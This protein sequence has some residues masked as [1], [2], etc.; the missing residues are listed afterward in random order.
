MC[1]VQK[2]AGF[3]KEDAKTGN[4]TVW[5]AERQGNTPSKE[6]WLRRYRMRREVSLN[7]PLRR[8]FSETIHETLTDKLQISDTEAVE[9]Y[10]ASMLIEFLNFDGIYAIRDAT[11]RRVESVLEMLAEG[12]VRMN[13]DSFDREREVHRHIGDFLLFWSGL[14][15]EYLAGRDSVV[16][17][18]RQGQFSYHVVSTFEHEPYANEAQTFRKLSVHFDDFRAGLNLLRGSFDGFALR[19]WPEGFDA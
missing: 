3:E 13:A 9:N 12:D 1:G 5:K 7:H 10:L 14:F 18:V 15:P 2:Y 8:F 16:D 17:V 4:S 6:A 19:R 11:G